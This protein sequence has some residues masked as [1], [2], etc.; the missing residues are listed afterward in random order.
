MAAIWFAIALFDATQTVWAMRAE[1]MHHAWPQLFLTLLLSWLPWALATPIVLRLG[2]RY[3]PLGWVPQNW[4]IHLA[5][6]ASIGVVYAT[7]TAWL[8]T[9]MNPWAKPS[10]PGNFLD[11]SFYKFYEGVLSSLILYFSILAVGY[12]LDSRERL[13]RHQMETARLNEQLSREQLNALRRQIEPHFLFNALNAIAGL[14]REGRNDTAVSM[15]AG[16]SDVLRRLVEDST[17]QE[18]PLA[19]EM[20]F[21]EKYLEIQKMRFG[22]RLRLTMNVPP[23]LLQTPVPRL[24]LQPMVENAVKHGIEKSAQGG[25]VHIAAFRNNGMLTLSVYNDGPGLLVDWERAT[26]GIGITNVRSRLQRLYGDAF[27]LSLH[28]HGSGGVEASV[29]IPYRER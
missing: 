18:A 6:W 22:D 9:L 4:L 19:E 2:Q 25:A 13:A 20:E 27:Q 1:G 17:R 5:G 7:W 29:S 8:E 28:N 3:S 24:I 26:S 10:G 23:E 14:V 12:V 16:L 15:I 21:L 11:L